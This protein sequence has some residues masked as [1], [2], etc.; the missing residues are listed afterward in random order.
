[1]GVRVRL[2]K[3]AWW[4]FVTHRGQ[5]RA[6]RVGD[7]RAAEAVA[8]QLRARLQ[9]GDLSILEHERDAL[10][11]QAYAERWLGTYV[12]V[13]CKPRTLELYTFL[14]RRHLFP[15]LGAVALPDLTRER[16]R[17]LFASKVGAGMRRSTALKVVGLLRE[18][19]N[20]AVEDGHLASNPATR[21]SRFY[22]GRTEQEARPRVV[23][24]TE[25][26]LRHL[27]ATCKRWYPAWL[28]LIATAAWTGLRQGEVL[29][30]Q[31]EDLDFAGGFIDVRRTVAYTG[32]T[33]RAGSPKS[34]KARRVD[35]PAPLAGALQARKSLLE[36][37]AA[38]E[39]RDPTPWV[40]PNKAGKPIDALNLLHR[41]W[42]PLLDKAGLRR[43]RFHDLRHT[44]A[45]LL[46]QRGESLAYVKEQL[47]HS[48]IQVTVDLYGHLVPGTNRGAVDRLA[49]ATG[50]NLYATGDEVLRPE[51]SGSDGEDW[52]RGRELNPRPTD[53]E[54][55]ALPLSYPGVRS[56]S[57][58]LAQRSR[59]MLNVWFQ[60]LVPG[61]RGAPSPASRYGGG[62]GRG[63]RSVASSR[64]YGGRGSPVRPAVVRPA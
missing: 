3:G 52:S 32:G 25:R 27:L 47:G 38:L 35:L 1:M 58:S 12:A 21:L 23:P 10:S 46:I 24:L 41:V 16:V 64:G 42:H 59:P 7:R 19:L 14:C 53:Y 49:A 29:G 51:R 6:K 45:S 20:H 4:V 2:W 60:D 26:E 62:R 63:G 54:S 13:H 28:D 43:I 30:L 18:I 5:R 33:L 44:Y 8:S 50:C 36:A 55:V 56:A 37:E 17:A 40:H 31:W 34:G 22:R 9:L 39:G 57:L 48:S 15:E 11:L 61:P